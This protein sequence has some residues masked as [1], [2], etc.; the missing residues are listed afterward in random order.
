MR[1]AG[2]RAATAGPAGRRKVRRRASL[3][4]LRRR[5]TRGFAARQRPSFEDVVGSHGPL[6]PFVL[7]RQD[8]VEG[9]G[10]RFPA[11]KPGTDRL[12]STLPLRAGF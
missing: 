11:T 9:V 5:R 8:E 6:S 7:R 1:S 2:V 12:S 10:R 3:T 4:V